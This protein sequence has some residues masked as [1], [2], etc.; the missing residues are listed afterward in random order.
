MQIK[1]IELPAI[2]ISML[3][4]EAS[5][6]ISLLRKA[7]VGINNHETRLHQLAEKWEVML[8]NQIT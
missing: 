5:D 2:Q 8:H 3:K 1:Q 7:Q 6:L 4:H